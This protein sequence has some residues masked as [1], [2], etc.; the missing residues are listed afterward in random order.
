MDLD[1]YGLLADADRGRLAAAVAGVR[2]R[3]RRACGRRRP[4]SGAVSFC[5]LGFLMRMPVY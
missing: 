1:G 3:Q 5:N 4:Q 2:G